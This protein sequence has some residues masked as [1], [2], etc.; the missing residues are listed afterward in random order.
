[1]YMRTGHTKFTG[2]SVRSYGY[3][4]RRGGI[5]RIFCYPVFVSEMNS[6]DLILYRSPGTGTLVTSSIPFS[7]ALP[8]RPFDHAAL[9]QPFTLFLLFIYYLFA[10]PIVIRLTHS[11]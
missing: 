7:S 11:N 4:L 5:S 2:R 3:G 9:F 1:M 8:T 6:P 10:T